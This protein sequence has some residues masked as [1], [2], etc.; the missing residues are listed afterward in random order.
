MTR[1]DL[2]TG[3]RHMWAL[4]RAEV[5]SF[6]GYAVILA[7]ITAIAGAP[8]W[9]VWVYLGTGLVPVVV[10]I[11]SRGREAADH[12]AFAGWYEAQDYEL[13][14]WERELLAGEDAD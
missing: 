10:R 7:A 6:A 11:Y 14:D 4:D 3:A 12:R 1:R 5:L 8:H 2:V 13:A 9:L